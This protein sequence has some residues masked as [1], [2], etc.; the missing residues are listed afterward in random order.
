MMVDCGIVGSLKNLRREMGLESA[1][2]IIL[3]NS[4]ALDLGAGER[5]SARELKLP[6]PL[7]PLE[8]GYFIALGGDFYGVPDPIRAQNPSDWQPISS[9]PD[10]QVAF[11]AAWGSL[12]RADRAELDRILGVMIEELQAVQP[13]GGLKAGQKPSDAYAGLGDT[14]SFK[15]NEIT[16]GASASLGQVG[17][18]A[19]PGRYLKLAKVNMD[20]FGRDAVVAYTAGHTAAMKMAA[21]LH[22]AAPD[23]AKEKLLQIYTANAFADHFLTDLFSAGHLRTP[24]RAL[25]EMSTTTRGESG[26]LAR[27]MHNEDN[28]DGLRVRNAR[29]ESWRCFGDGKELDD[30]SKDNFARAQAAVQASADEIGHAFRTG[31]VVSDLAVRQ[32]IPRLDDFEPQ[33]VPGAQSHS[34]LFWADPKGYVYRRGGVGGDLPPFSWKDKNDYDYTYYGWSAAVMTAVQGI[35][36]LMPVS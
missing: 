11:G 7:R 19:D 24:R 15:W 30:E 27:A 4:I 6:H 13:P 34:A 35:S 21:G 26:F 25:Y 1:E 14:L 33:P 12:I 23:K 20:H 29:G 8:Y 17:A 28:A 16:G 31:E 18:I 2:H 10:P 32:L 5:V 3:G 36:S 9:C 22:G